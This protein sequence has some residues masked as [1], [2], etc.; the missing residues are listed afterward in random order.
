MPRFALGVL[1]FQANAKKSRF[2]LSCPDHRPWRDRI[3]LEKWRPGK[4]TE[5]RKNTETR[6]KKHQ[7]DHKENTTREATRKK[8]VIETRRKKCQ[9]DHKE[10]NGNHKENRAEG[11]H[12]EKYQGNQKKIMISHASNYNGCVLLWLPLPACPNTKMRGPWITLPTV[13][14]LPPSTMARGRPFWHPAPEEERAE[15]P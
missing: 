8:R 3:N 5:K 9:G 7:G 13:A 4:R 11:D 14:S 6:K 12:K 15:R 2:I 1:I 10:T